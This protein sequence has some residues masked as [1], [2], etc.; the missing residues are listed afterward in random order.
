MRFYFLTL[1]ILNILLGLLTS[2]SQMSHKKRSQPLLSDDEVKALRGDN[3]KS[4]PPPPSPLSP[5][6]ENER[7]DKIRSKLPFKFISH[8]FIHNKI[9]N[10]LYPHKAKEN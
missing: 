6:Q 2:E 5:Q 10:K 3:Y 7:L 9:M 8:P 4:P 1:S